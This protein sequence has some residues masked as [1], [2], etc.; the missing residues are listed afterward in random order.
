MLELDVFPHRTQVLA[1]SPDSQ[2]LFVRVRMRVSSQAAT[3]K[4]DNSVTLFILVDTSGSMRSKLAQ[5]T[6]KLER[7]IDA[8]SSIS[9]LAGSSRRTELGLAHFD[10]VSAILLPP[11]VLDEK[12]GQTL[13]HAATKLRNFSGGTCLEP[14]L[15]LIHTGLRESGSVVKKAVILTDGETSDV[16]SCLDVVTTFANDGISLINVGIGADYNEDFLS[17][18]AD[19]TNG[20]LYHLSETED[21]LAGMRTALWEAILNAE[22][23]IVT[24]SRLRLDT[25]AGVVVDAFHRVYPMVQTVRQDSDGRYLIGN[26]GAKEEINLLAEL[27]LPRH[28]LGLRRVA[29]LSLDY[30]GSDGV[31]SDH[32]HAQHLDINYSADVG[33]SQKVDDDVVFYVRQARLTEMADLA[34]LQAK[35]GDI[36]A[37]QKSIHVVERLSKKIGNPD[38]RRMA[39]E[40]AQELEEHRRLAPNTMKALKVGAKTKTLMAPPTKNL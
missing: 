30:S 21:S 19:E 31:R 10:T 24:N 18:L 29:T 26:I 15:Q 3:R 25:E 2:K 13:I 36:D 38:L 28:S 37:A 1:N 4:S 23:E 8:I 17:R 22:T 33:G 20:F 35:K 34:V 32:G 27:T 5:G 9:E 40:A 16:S 7:A 12:A 39:R 14:A 6:S 11:T